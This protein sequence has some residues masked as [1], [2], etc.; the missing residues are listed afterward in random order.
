MQTPPSH[1]NL[2][3]RSSRSSP[4]RSTAESRVQATSAIL[5]EDTTD[6]QVAIELIEL[7][8]QEYCARM[9]MEA[10]FAEGVLNCL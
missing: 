2:H 8:Y 4:R 9:E 7:R 10:M 3:T 5:I 6:M 1:E